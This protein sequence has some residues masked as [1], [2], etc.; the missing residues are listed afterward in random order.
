MAEYRPEEIARLEQLYSANP[1]SRVFTHLAEAYR[2]QGD[3]G[4]ARQILEDGLR[5]HDGYASAHVVLGRVLTGMG[6]GD[7]AAR[8]YRRVLDLDPENRIALDALAAYAQRR[9]DTAAA[10]HHVQRLAQ[11][12]PAEEEI[13]AT[14]ARLEREADA[15][16][17]ALG[18][19]WTGVDP[20]ASA[21]YG[22][23]GAAETEPAGSGAGAGAPPEFEP[24]DHLLGAEFGAPGGTDAAGQDPFAA[25]DAGWDGSADAEQ[26]DEPARDDAWPGADAGGAPAL[27]FDWGISPPED[28]RANTADADATDAG[29]PAAEWLSSINADWDTPGGLAFPA[30]AAEP[31]SAHV[32]DTDLEPDATG[33]GA[34]ALHDEAAAA[35]DGV[36]GE[37]MGA[38]E[39]S[40]AA[41]TREPDRDTVAGGDPL[42]DAAETE[43]YTE[44]L[45]ELYRAQG[46]P[47]RAAGVYRSL[48]SDRP[49]DQRLMQ[50]LREIEGEADATP[51]APGDTRAA[52]QWIEVAEELERGAREASASHAREATA[53]ADRA[54]AEDSAPGDAGGAAAGGGVLEDAAADDSTAWRAAPGQAA[55]ATAD[56]APDADR[57]SAVDAEE[58]DARSVWTAGASGADVADSPYAW[59]AEP[60]DAGADA[61]GPSIR[62]LLG[63]LLAWRPTRVRSVTAPEEPE[64][65]LL[66]LQ[67]EER[68]ADPDVD[69][70]DADA[71]APDAAAADA[72]P[73]EDHA[74]PEAG[75]D[76]DWAEAGTE[77]ERR[78][79]ETAEAE[80][81]QTE[82]AVAE[83]V[84]AEPADAAAPDGATADAET[85][86]I[87]TGDAGE[88]Y[89]PMP[90]EIDEPATG[91]APWS[92]RDVSWDHTARADAGA[93]PPDDAD[94]GDTAADGGAKDRADPAPRQDAGPPGAE[95]GSAPATGGPRRRAEGSGAAAA[96]DD[97]D[98]EMFR[99]WLQSLRK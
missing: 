36:A 74:A 84:A 11:L 83:A 61:D 32:A 21:A 55:D 77:P 49:N 62:A 76:A 18:G 6:D 17:G 79:A 50:K 15:G 53:V 1:D 57:S 91:G 56:G 69:A 19:M 54:T 47:E 29:Q 30:G 22:N 28:A 34:R 58:D 63:G 67:E 78:D 86:R 41:D 10:L 90:W 89:E 72:A 73:A 39:D 4:R 70:P 66:L 26:T 27:R 65:A 13:R 97:D 9:G 2:K 42:P 52:A 88:P 8:E 25:L 40:D 64:E 92:G 96:D 43:V 94:V 3:L 7:A 80:P 33:A 35:D 98:L 23:A 48:L 5:R 99:S 60:A 85:A 75:A 24:L 95:S 38:A 81:S 71:D 93:A 20:F 12:D 51:H 46:F 31:A 87:E 82:P 37:D 14:L 45:A 44:T 68:A 59:S 16:T